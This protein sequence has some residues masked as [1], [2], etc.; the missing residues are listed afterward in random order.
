MLIYEKNK[1]TQSIAL[2]FFRIC[3]QYR[4][5]ANL[6]RIFSGAKSERGHLWPTRATHTPFRLAFIFSINIHGGKE[7][8]F[9]DI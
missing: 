6:D 3:L 8:R 2:A 1:N 7:K 4:T 9:N 5:F